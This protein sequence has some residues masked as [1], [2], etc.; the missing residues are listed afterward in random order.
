M[1]RKLIFALSLLFAAGQHDN[2]HCPFVVG[3]QMPVSGELT[4][5]FKPPY[6]KPMCFVDLGEASLEPT[7]AFVRITTKP[8]AY[9]EI[10]CREDAQ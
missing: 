9:V 10:R 4:L 5:Y 6:V 1:L 7:P 2:P 3:I 8:S